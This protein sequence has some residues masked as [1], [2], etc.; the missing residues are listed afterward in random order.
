MSLRIESNRTA[1]VSGAGAVGQ[2]HLLSQGARGPE[3]RQ[4]QTQLKN[5]G[6]SP[7]SVDGV[8]GPKTA[9]AVK[10]YQRAKGLQVDGVAGQQTWGSFAGVRLPPGSSKLAA[11]GP[12]SSNTG[13]TQGTSGSRPVDNFEPVSGPGKRVTAY[14]NGQPRSISVVPVGN[15]EYM[16]ADAA[17]AFKAMQAAAARDGIQLPAV[18]GF[19]SMAEQQALYQKYLNGTGNLAAKPGYSNHQNGIAIDIGGVGGFNTRTFQWLKSHAGQYGFVNKVPGE[20]WH[21]DYVR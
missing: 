15:G 2:H 20:Y 7:G 8:F 5:A 9:A 19:R 1:G 12:R 4:L 14:V 3:V 13:G 11:G 10:A 16:R 17:G 6:F 18:S 21:F